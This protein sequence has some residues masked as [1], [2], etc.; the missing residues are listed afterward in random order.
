MEHFNLEELCNGQF[1]EQVNREIE[2]VM[3]NIYDPN[4]DA[5]T[6]RKITIVIGFKPNEQR[7]FIATGVQAKSTLA[8]QLGAVTA[9]SMGK[10]LKTGKIEACEIGN[11]IPGQMSVQEVIGDMV[12]EETSAVKKV[13]PS[14]GEI[15][16][17]PDNNVVDFRS[18]RQA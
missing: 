11:Q 6:A 1:T 9:I 13:D 5:K 17:T 15:Y 2:R 14:T 8:P 7:N 4:T 3:E 16:E 12:A 10:N 18:A